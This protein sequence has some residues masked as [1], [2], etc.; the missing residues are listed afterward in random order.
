MRLMIRN[1][2][3]LGRYS[4]RWELLV[5]Y[6]IDELIAH[7][8]THFTDGMSWESFGEWEVEHVVPRREFEYASADDPAFRECWALSNL[9]PEWR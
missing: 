1:S 6:T 3:G 8:E 4:W 2:L 9:K 5:A 7:L